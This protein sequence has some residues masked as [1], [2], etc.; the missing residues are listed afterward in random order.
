[1]PHEKDSAVFN[2]VASTGPHSLEC[3][4]PMSLDEDEQIRVWLQRG[5]TR[6]SA[7]CRMEQPRHRATHRF[8]GAALVGVR[9]ADV[10]RC[11]L[12]LVA[13]LQRGRT[14]WSAECAK[15]GY[16]LLP[17]SLASTGPHSL[18]CGMT[19]L[20]STDSGTATGFNG[21]ALVGVRNADAVK[22]ELTA[23]PRLQRGRTRWS[24]E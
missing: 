16:E 7:E 4:M 2:V 13:L 12:P 6:W 15:L 5:R 24:A 3:G 8:N 19:M 20:L 17:E 18:E 11:E 9:N 14:R 22:E 10:R 23:R 21:A 1:M